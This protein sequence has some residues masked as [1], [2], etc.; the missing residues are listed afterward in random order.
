MRRLFLPFGLLL[1]VSFFSTRLMANTVKPAEVPAPSTIV[2]FIENK[3]QWSP[4][5]QFQA[6][7]PGGMVFFEQGQITYNL[8][9]LK[10]LHDAYFH[11]TTNRD[12]TP[13]NYPGHAFQLH[14]DGGNAQARISPSEKYPEYNN[15]F[16]GN[17]PAKW[18]SAVGIFAQ[19]NYDE[20]YPGIDAIF[21]GK[22]ASVKYD[23]VVSPWADADLIQLRYAGLEGMRIAYNG[24]M[25]FPTSIGEFTEMRPYAYQDI[26]GER[27]G[28][29]CEF[30][31]E[32]NVVR[33][34][35]PQGYDRAHTLVIDPTWVFGS[36]SG[37]TSD[38]FGYTATFDTSGNLYGGG[39]AFGLG[40]PTSVG[41]YQTNYAGGGGPPFGG[42]GFDMSISKFNPT[43]TALV[44][45]TYI[46]GSLNEQPQSMITNDAGELVIYGR[47]W[48]ND[49]PTTAGAAHTTFGGSSDIVVVKL[50]AAGTGLIG[51]TF[52]GGS[53]DDGLNI[54]TNYG[55]GI[56]SLYHNYGDDSRG[57]VMLDPAGNIYIA[58]C[59]QSSNFP[60]TAGC[61]QAANGGA[62]DAVV[63]RLNPL[64][65]TVAWAT[66]LGGSGNDAAY[67]IKIDLNG[68][69]FVAGGTESPNFPTTNGVISSAYK[70][71]IDG[72]IT[73]FNPA[74]SAITAST[75]IGTPDYDQCFFLE[76]DDAQDIFVVGQTLGAFPVTPGVYN[77]ANGNQFI[78]KY[79]PLLTTTSFSTVF[80]NGTGIVD[81]SP[82]AFLVDRCGFVYVAGWGGADN[83]NFSVPTNGYTTGLPTTP[84]A[85]QTTTDGSD[86]YILI[87]TPNALALEY[88]T[89][90]G[91]PISAEHVDGGTS[92]FD[93]DLR[94]YEAVCSGC[95]G[96]SDFP[97]SV[98]AVSQTNNS[99][100]CNI[101][102]FKFAFDPQDIRASFASQTFDSCAP[103][104]VHFTNTSLGGVTFTWDFGDGSPIFNGFNANHTY[105]LPGTYNV[106]LTIVDSNSC[107]IVDTVHHTVN[108]FANPIVVAGG[109]DTICSGNAAQIYTSGGVLYDWSPGATL[110]DSTI[111]TPQASPSVN[112]TYTVIVTDIHG[113]VDTAS[114][115]IF[116]THYFADAGPPANF[117]E[118]TGGAQLQAGAI[119]GGTGPFYY[120]WTCDTVLTFCGLDST[121]DDD[122]RA[123]PSQTTMY[124]LQVSDSR[125]CL[126]ELDSTLVTV[127]P[128]PIA[129][130][131]PDQYICQQPAP[132]AI[133]QGS[134]SNAP[135]PYVFFWSPSIGLN[136]NTILNP[137]ARPDTTTIY[138]LVGISSNGCTSA[139][140]TLDT[141]ST[142]V[143]H[144]QP[145]PIADAGPDMHTCLGDTA[146]IQGLGYGAGPL[147]KYEWTPY[148]GLSDSTVPNPVATPPFTHIYTLVVWSNGCPSFG[149]SMTYWVHTL[150]TPSP[151]NIR[152]ICLGDTAYLDAFAAGDSS[153]SYTY[154]WTPTLGLNSPVLENPA[155]SPDTSTWYTL[156]ATSSWGCESPMD[157]VLVLVKP[158]PIADAGPVQQICAGDSVVLQGSYSYA[159]TDSA[160]PSQIWYTWTPA[161]TINDTTL[162]QPTVWPQQATMYYFA[163]RYN[164]CETYDSVLVILSPG[165]GSFANA[166]TST[167][168]A[169]DSVGLHAGG[170]L[171]AAQ[172][173]WVPSAGL[174]DPH[175]FDPFAAPADTTVYTAII[176]EGGCTEEVSVQLNVIPS[177][178]AAFTHSSLDGCPPH[179]MSFTD[180]SDTTIFHIWNFG[181]GSP[182]SNSSHPEHTYL[183]PG[184]YTVTHEVVSV[185][186]C[187]GMGA[188]VTVHVRDTIRADFSSDPDYPAN[189][190][191][192]MTAVSFFDQTV[193]A[194]EVQW[195]FGD[196]I[197]GHEINP[198][199]TYTALGQ[200]F[201]TLTVWTAEG[202]KSVVTH[203]PYNILPSDVFLPNVFSPNGDGINDVFLVTYT[204]SQP[205]FVEIFDRWGVKYFASKDKL[206][207]WDGATE[208]GEALPAGV[209]Y[210]HLRIGDKDYV[211]HVTLLR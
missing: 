96:N 131:G 174:S 89:F 133:L 107:N 120:T 39:I 144:V 90:Y 187:A 93:R 155:A 79:N 111:A 113:C 184:D 52:M 191:F 60:V 204:G 201:V 16:I 19:V 18:A 128:I 14:F 59:T 102:V 130:A 97:T 126:A 156:V 164:T 151:G 172:I 162:A 34:L 26:D 27:V 88:A 106:I 83:L 134:F 53:G 66:Y 47:A 11:C 125:G 206:Q 121:F 33:F 193:G 54:T 38:N 136:N 138:T 57:E 22:D 119:T 137:F 5:I 92:R 15:Y 55:P 171:G 110:D 100:N 25:V 76:I 35:F 160:N 70:G 158:T 210:Y 185:G 115:D 48:S 50:N 1:C 186:G 122:P 13:Y 98:G 165:L 170:G 84:G 108:V 196:G 163:V 143:V 58:S 200:Y 86:F 192:P 189:L 46:G 12:L 132:G 175:S 209:Y 139:P 56:Q 198:V 169:G 173:Q 112:T 45:S 129:D 85:F 146:V 62:Q 176:S 71:A 80:G 177:P 188:G 203:G 87:L 153:A 207:G 31:L 63:F 64:L 118:G 167:A 114:V 181:D 61:F 9:N 69:P 182:V 82:T 67:S 10:N 43:G 8:A 141:L 195:N 23:F 205:F 4:N 78:A 28:V 145:R 208:A 202:C 105:T 168:C 29:P 30:G 42:L 24:D 95:G 117:C 101:G 17:D 73:R 140:T 124:Y 77:N 41:A 157:S 180:L 127:L 123:N 161:T 65:T 166:D 72:Y 194:A 51:S 150:P 159:A 147:Y 109:S 154:V 199:H 94:I 116:V 74:G 183:R 7:I 2:K 190:Q 81:I 142:V 40:Y 32:G 152:E 149:D 91:G 44:W 197:L 103:F 148:V 36:F 179:P 6:G 211:D 68:N 178:G 104:P 99:S 135:G 20:I 49:F 21:Y 37:S 75:F 3:G